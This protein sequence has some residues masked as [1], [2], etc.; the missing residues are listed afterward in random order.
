MEEI[1]TGK[2]LEE[3]IS[4]LGLSDIEG[5]GYGELKY[6]YDGRV[7]MYAYNERSRVLVQDLV[8]IQQFSMSL[9]YT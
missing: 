6:S 5:Y 2:V 7:Q 8:E 3:R 9:I 1:G 4:H